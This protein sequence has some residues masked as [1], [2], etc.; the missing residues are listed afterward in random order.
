VWRGHAALAGI[1]FEAPERQALLE[2]IGL[3]ELGEEVTWLR[4]ALAHES[5]G[6]T[7]AKEVGLGV[8]SEGCSG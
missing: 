8:R 5:Y 6:V 1:T 7:R 2:S 4:Q 3:G